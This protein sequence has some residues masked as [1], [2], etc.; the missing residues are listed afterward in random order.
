M[1]WKHHDHPWQMPEEVAYSLGEIFRRSSPT[2]PPAG[3]V[4]GDCN[5]LN[6][7]RTSDGWVLLDWENS[8]NMGNLLDDVFHYYV[9]PNALLGRPSAAEIRAGLRG[10][11]LVGQT[12]RAYMSRAE[13][14]PQDIESSFDA[15]LSLRRHGSDNEMTR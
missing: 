13:D 7:R 3:L 11:D 4:H 1:E 10:H 9:T 2:A 8:S 14:R 5:P 15:F 6:L 12:L